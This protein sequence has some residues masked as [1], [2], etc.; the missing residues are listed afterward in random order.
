MVSGLGANG[1]GWA[2]HLAEWFLE[3]NDDAPPGRDK[4]VPEFYSLGVALDRAQ[5]ISQRIPTDTASRLR[6]R[7]RQPIASV[8]SAGFCDSVQRRDGTPY[9]GVGDFV[10]NLGS[11]ATKLLALGSESC[12]ASLL[13]VGLTPCSPDVAK[14][15]R[16]LD[17]AYSN[18]RLLEFEDAACKTVREL[19]G[20]AV[21]LM[22]QL[23]VE[24]FQDKFVSSDGIHPNAEG[25]RLVAHRVHSPF[26]E[27][28]S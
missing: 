8:L 10:T 28:M 15:F 7:R 5:H 12:P 16:G 27:M 24:G 3:R 9:F 13:Y 14:G 6:H 25:H 4:L 20:V 1:R 17:C 21:P 26:I 18:D 11:A 23:M 19:G 2:S 22:E